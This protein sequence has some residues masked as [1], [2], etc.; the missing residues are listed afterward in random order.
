MNEEKY[1]FKMKLNPGM[2][3]EYR[4]RHDEIW[5]ELSDLLHEAGVRDYSIFLD[6]ETYILFAVMWRRKDHG[7]A[8]LPKHPVMQRWW[9]HMSDIMETH[10]GNEP[11]T[12]DLVPLFHMP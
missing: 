2:A 10:P 12:V 6:E 7:M 3:A 1:A 4:R 5:P 11:V 8:D 9:A